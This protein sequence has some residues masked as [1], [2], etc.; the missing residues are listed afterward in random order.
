MAELAREIQENLLTGQQADDI[1]VVYDRHRRQGRVAVKNFDRLDTR[2]MRFNRPHTAR[3]I[4]HFKAML[5]GERRN[6]GNKRCRCCIRHILILSHRQS[7]VIFI[8]PAA[9]WA[10]ELRAAY[11]KA[12]SLL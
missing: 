2:D 5:A 9:P 6:F 4:M 10:P 8:A 12:M 7:S 3:D 1:A 11:V